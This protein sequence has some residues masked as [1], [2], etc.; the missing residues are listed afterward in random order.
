MIPILKRIL[1][2]RIFVDY[3][4]MEE[5]HWRE[6]G[7]VR[8]AITMQSKTELTFVASKHLKTWLI[9][10]RV[11]PTKVSVAFVGVDLNK[12]KPNNNEKS[13]LRSALGF[14]DSEIVILYNCRLVQQKQPLVMA[15][16]VREVLLSLKR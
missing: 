16:T 1:P 5:L 10:Q 9:D 14:M 6:E 11:S 2:N 3:V 4:H 13:R 8:H 12:W 7:H 15:E